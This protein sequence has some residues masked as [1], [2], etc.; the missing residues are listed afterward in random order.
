LC[1]G[2]RSSVSHINCR[3]SKVTFLHKSLIVTCG[4]LP[5]NKAARRRLQAKSE[6]TKLRPWQLESFKLGVNSSSSGKIGLRGP[7]SGDPEAGVMKRLILMYCAYGGWCGTLLERQA[8]V[9]RSQTSIRTL[10]ISCEEQSALFWEKSRAFDLSNLP[11]DLPTPC[12]NQRKNALRRKSIT[13][14]G[15]TEHPLLSQVAF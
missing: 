5:P 8:Q 13:V 15:L 7:E 4:A 10:I 14:D 9:S 11:D 2:G 3:Q 6:V 12:S 1:K